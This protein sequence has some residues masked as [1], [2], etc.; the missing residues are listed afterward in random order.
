MTG[1]DDRLRSPRPAVDEWGIYD[2]EQAGLDA[3]YARLDTLRRIA[4]TPVDRAFMS[5]ARD[6]LTTPI[7]GHA[8]A[9]SMRE[10]ARR[11]VGSRQSS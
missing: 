5:R 8:L 9:A 10:A 7:D 6:V 11:L 1:S 2:P 3:L 4:N